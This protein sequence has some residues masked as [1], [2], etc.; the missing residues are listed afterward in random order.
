MKLKEDIKKA[1]FWYEES[2]KK[3]LLKAKMDDAVSE[4]ETMSE[5]LGTISRTLD[6]NFAVC[7][8]GEAGIGKSTLINSIIDDTEYIVPSGGGHGPLTAN[9]LR[10]V[11][12]EQKKINVLYHGRDKIKET[13]QKLLKKIRKENKSENDAE[14]EN[15][16]QSDEAEDEQEEKLKTEEDK[17]KEIIEAE[18]KARIL[19]CGQQ[20]QD[21]DPEY[22]VSCLRHILKIKNKKNLP[23][24]EEHKK[25]LDEVI[26]AVNLGSSK[27][28]REITFADRNVFRTALAAHA[29]G[30]L[31]PLVFEM[32][33]EWPSQTLKHSLEIIDLPGVGIH[34]DLYQST[35]SEFLRL[36]AKAVM[37]VVRDR[38]LTEE[39]VAVLKQSGF[40]N[41]FLHSLHDP[42]SDPVRILATVVHIDNIAKTAWQ[43]DKASTPDGRAIKPLHEHFSD[44]AKS[45][46]ENIARETK[47]LIAKE[48]NSSDA[49]LNEDQQQIIDRL[50]GALGVF[51]I[52][53]LQYRLNTSPDPD[54]FERPFL[55]VDQSGIPS[56]RDE[57]GNIATECCLEREERANRM[58]ESFLVS[59]RSHLNVL[60]AKL[61]NGTRLEN[62]RSEFESA[63]NSYI[64]GQKSGYHHR[65]GSFRSFL[66]K[67]IPSQI[68]DKVSIASNKAKD[69]MH[70]L[71]E[72]MADYPWNTI[73]AAVTRFG[74]Y[75]GAKHI[76]LPEQ[77]AVLFEAPVARVWSKEILSNI[78][79][80]TLGFTDYEG[81]LLE[82]IFRWAKKNYVNY[83]TD[84]LQALISEVD[85]RRKQLN[86]LSAH[87]INEQG[88]EVKSALLTLIKNKVRNKCVRFV[89]A[90]LHHG[91]GV[92][93]RM[94]KMF[95]LIAKDIAEATAPPVGELLNVKFKL[96]EETILKSFKENSNPLEDAKEALI[97]RFDKK[98]ERDGVKG[99][100]ILK[101]IEKALPQSPG[102]SKLLPAS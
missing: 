45:S 20:N 99:N 40:L 43:K 13:L 60:S 21:I 5:N 69:D 74:T 97:E 78:K 37:L 24:K 29:T 36:K 46:K 62:E 32:R 50:F 48:W 27:K 47:N 87:A 38:G 35:T 6:E 95:Y 1:K 81:Q 89:E 65:K 57:L 80:E 42:S 59:A 51:P 94:I 52:S 56:L 26:D 8:L 64:E 53:A 18:R 7:V 22:L 66:R 100:E 98:L 16:H 71:I 83:R 79:K 92:K 82:E 28:Q 11:H 93:L 102:S 68:E 70:S 77:F 33:I 76:N 17:E 10:V 58:L 25:N 101:L 9:A 15:E 75:Y 44:A 85:V 12:S 30:H 41:R 39:S 73:R 14:I 2:V 67:S 84:L 61:S 54:E 49:G 88:G 55:N 90:N 91:P 31:S 96:V 34:N 19:V 86:D 23:I 4:L 63:L 72:A 3:I